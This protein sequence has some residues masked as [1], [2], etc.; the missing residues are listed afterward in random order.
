MGVLVLRKFVWS[1]N[2]KIHKSLFSGLF[3]KIA[4]IVCVDY[5]EHQ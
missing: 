1:W 5:E 2:S 3:A 4:R